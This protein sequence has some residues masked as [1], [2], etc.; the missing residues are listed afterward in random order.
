MVFHQIKLFSM[1]WLRRS[2]AFLLVDLLIM[3]LT[4]ALASWQINST[5]L[6]SSYYSEVL[7]QSD[8]YSFLLTDVPASA[9]S[10]LRASDSGSGTLGIKP[11]EALGIGPQEV[12]SSIN[13][14]LPASWVQGVVEHV[15][16]QLGGYMTGERDQFLV[17]IRFDDRVDALSAEFKRLILRSN[18]YDVIFD[19]FVAPQLADTV[20]SGLPS[21]LDITERDILAAVANIAP[22][23]WV[24]PQFVA[25]V[26][27][28][29][30][31]LAGKADSF[32]VVVPLDGR[33]EIA[34][35]E[36]KALLRSS[37]AYESLYDQ[38]IDPLVYES[39]GGGLQ[40]PYGIQLDDREIATAL[41]QVAPPEWIQAQAEQIIDDAT[42]FLIGKTDTFSTIVSLTEIK[43]NAVVVLEDSVARELTDLV[44]SLPD[45]RDTSLQQIL[46]AGLQGTVECLPQNSTVQRLT[47]ILAER[48][49]DF[50]S[51]SIVNA[52][53]ESI[54]FTEQDLYD[55]LSLA[56]VPEGSGV[57]D[58]V[59]A[60]VR[61]GWR[62]T[63]EDFALHL[64]EL[65]FNEV[66]GQKASDSVDRIRSLM[67]D[68]WTFDDA[69]FAEYVN[70]EYPSVVP[71]LDSLRTYLKLARTFGFLIFLPVVLLVVSIA[72]V[73]GRGWS[74]RFTWAFG[75]LAAASLVILVMFGIVYGLI[76]G[77]MLDN[78][79]DRLLADALGAESFGATKF[80]ITNK[81]I[82][83]IE[84]VYD[85]F[86]SGIINRALMILAIS[87]F[88]LI[89]TLGW[90]YIAP[91]TRRLP[92]GWDLDSMRRRAVRLSK[93]RSLR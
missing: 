85:D 14:A 17:T 76:V 51:A 66:D 9:V 4:L 23:E 6:R 44:A 38:L 33:V 87:I 29:T 45:C 88:G 18:T 78:I 52:I 84:S 73:G 50:V 68:G 91:L 86:S 71:T 2:L 16:N 47:D 41:R 74:G 72:Y 7:D 46:A 89:V 5:F 31:Y 80:I 20:A 13:A 36:V 27:E 43:V 21:G 69:D 28:V 11:L 53:P 1:K 32:E 49:A 55:T 54:V 60:R 62:Y 26:D 39:L 56:G 3:V 30:P 42:P 19:Q 22:K 15:I 35:Q 65:A 34:L 77:S 90:D 58:S 64:G 70:S 92:R 75:S 12:V 24:E 37:G 82:E 93:I 10:E 63:D 61:N 57:I 67:L 40:L 83:I 8:V 48:I 25:A 81:L 79:R 59:R